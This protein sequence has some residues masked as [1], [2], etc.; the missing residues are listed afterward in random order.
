[1]LKEDG[2]HWDLEFIDSI[3]V[4]SKNKIVFKLK[5]PRSTFASSQLVEVPIVPKAHYDENYKQNPI[6]SG[7]YKVVEYKPNEQAIFEINPYWHGEKPYFKKWTWVL[8]EENTALA[9]LESGEVDMIYATP[10][11]A[12]K[13]IDGCKLF[14][15]ES[16]DVRGLSMPYVKKGVINDSPD[17][18]TVG[19]NVT[20]DP[21]IRKAL[22]IGMDRQKV[23]DT[24]LNGHGKPAYS[25][26]D[27]T[28][29]WNSEAIIEDNKPEEAKKILDENGW[30]VGKDGIREKDG[31]K[32]EFELYYPTQDQIRT[33][34]AVEA[35]NQAKELGINIKLVGSNWDEM[36][37]KSHEVA[38]LYAGGRHNPNQFFESHHPSTAGKGWTNITFY[39]NPKVTEYLEKAMNSSDLEEA[40]KYWKLAQWDGNVGASVKGDIANVWLA[41]INHTYL[42][43]S[44]INVGN[45]GMHSHGHDWALIANISE[46][47]WEESK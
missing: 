26:I 18:Y 5:S 9:S 2:K 39:N 20:S 34:V 11:F 46:W 21:I 44:R 43:D 6:G 16:N 23:V 36:I 25:V 35:A 17:G 27:G 47:K 13:K 32:A 8:L 15:I 37:T 24:V 41:R 45:Q 42:G 33:N 1:M 28:S 31:I 19:N 7:P 3:E 29:F 4:P 10:E 14:D 38:L 12:D 40:N 30:V 22:N